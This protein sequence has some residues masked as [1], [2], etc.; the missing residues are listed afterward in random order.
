M[1]AQDVELVYKVKEYT[2]PDSK[3]LV[4]FF[5]PFAIRAWLLALPGFPIWHLNRQGYSVVAYS[6]P[7]AIAVKSVEVTLANLRAI[8]E[9]S[10]RRIA[11]I[12]PSVEISCFG[13]SMGTVLA[14]N[15][16]AEH[17]RIRK[18]ILNLPYADISDHIIALPGIRTIPSRRLKAYL[19]T[20]DNEQ[21]LKAAFDPYS[22]ITLIQEFKGKKLL[23]YSS[24][25][26]HILQFIHTAKFHEALRRADVDIE[27]HQNNRGRHFLAALVNYMHYRR[28]LRFLERA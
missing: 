28:W 19:S 15:V 10:R 4:F 8:I 27:Y 1:P 14:A 3:K 12:N 20:V 17:S 2:V 25:D 22:P 5:C 16:A 21:H 11:Q 6:Y 18:V 9:D 23:V 13:A 26:D 7:T 24:R